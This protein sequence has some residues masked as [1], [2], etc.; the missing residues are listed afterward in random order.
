[1]VCTCSFV[2]LVLVGHEFRGL[3]ESSG[4]LSSLPGLGLWSEVVCILPE[5]GSGTQPM[6]TGLV[7][8]LV[9]VSWCCLGTLLSLGMRQ[10]AG[11]FFGDP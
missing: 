7:Q 11:G 6:G 8:C 9:G 3:S 5:L 1:M 10:S 2:F 4:S